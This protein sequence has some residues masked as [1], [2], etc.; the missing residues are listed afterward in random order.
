MHRFRYV[1]LAI[2]L[3]APAQ[4]LRA[5]SP[6][7]DGCGCQP[8]TKKVCRLVCEEKEIVKRVYS[9]KCE[10]FCVPGKSICCK[11]PCGPTGLGRLCCDPYT[12]TP[13]CGC[14]RQRVVPVITDEKKKV[15][16]YKC[17]V[18]E[19]C[20]RCGHCC[21]RTDYPVADDPATALAMV[22]DRNIE[23]G[24]DVG[25]VPP[26]EPATSPAAATP[27]A[28]ANRSFIDRFFARK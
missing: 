6:C 25:P 3:L 21:Q 11:K 4:A 8:G 14:V 22:K 28:T 17:V 16:E 5:G 12:Y 15:P 7:C 13:T 24:T 27:A 10:D 19:V 26:A 9:C 18:E 20:V 23:R 2:L 1:S